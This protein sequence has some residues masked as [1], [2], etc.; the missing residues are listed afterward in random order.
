MLTQGLGT[1][2]PWPPA[3]VPQAQLTVQCG[4]RLVVTVQD[5]GLSGGPGWGPGGR[6]PCLSPIR[7]V[8]PLD[9]ELE[10]PVPVETEGGGGG[11]E[12]SGAAS[13]RMPCSPHPPSLSLTAARRGGTQRA[14]RWCGSACA[15]AGPS[16]SW[17]QSYTGC[18]GGAAGSSA[19]PCG[20]GEGAES[21]RCLGDHTQ[22][23]TDRAGR[24]R[25]QVERSHVKYKADQDLVLLC[26]ET[27]TSPRPHC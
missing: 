3:L 6:C 25:P 16:C 15:V 1:D 11:G 17:R 21:G 12:G 7:T 23:L 2:T 22:H 27:G 20:P 9:V 14:S 19:A 13:P 18:I 10:M 8:Q 24:A 26:V 4:Q 5:D